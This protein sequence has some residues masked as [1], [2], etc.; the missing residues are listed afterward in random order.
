MEDQVSPP[1]HSPATSL[2]R[3]YACIGPSLL[4]NSEVAFSINLVFSRLKAFPNLKGFKAYICKQ[5]CGFQII[6]KYEK[7]AS[8]EK[9]ARRKVVSLLASYLREAF[10]ESPTVEAQTAAAKACVAIFPCLKFEDND[11]LVSSKELCL[12]TVSFKFFS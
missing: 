8:L 6:A 2:K 1:L 7:T 9:S 11:E 10:G 4:I 5:D 12:V 3:T